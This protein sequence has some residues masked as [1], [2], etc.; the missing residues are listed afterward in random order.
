MLTSVRTWHY[1]HHP[2]VPLN[3]TWYFQPFSSDHFLPS[4]NMSWARILSSLLCF[5]S[6]FRQDGYFNTISRFINK[7]T[8][9]IIIRSSG[10]P[11]SS[12]TS[13]LLKKT[14][15]TTSFSE[16]R[17]VVNSW[18]FFT[19]VSLNW[20]VLILLFLQKYRSQGWHFSFSTFIMQ[21]HYLLFSTQWFCF[22]LSDLNYY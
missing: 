21:F 17:F 22:L 4:H 6:C 5:V 16:C 9:S 15:F 12:Q 18:L 10:G 13:S 7:S 3:G 8:I 19:V 1:H 20:K 2:P 11:L 14:S